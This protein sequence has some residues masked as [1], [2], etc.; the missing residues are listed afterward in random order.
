MRRDS[1]EQGARSQRTAVNFTEYA[2]S[3]KRKTMVPLLAP[4]RKDSTNLYAYRRTIGSHWYL[5]SYHSAANRYCI[6]GSLRKITANFYSLPA[7]CSLLSHSLIP[8]ANAE[9]EL[10]KFH[11]LLINRSTDIA[12]PSRHPAVSYLQRRRQMARPLCWF[13][14]DV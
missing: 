10:H 3:K 14:S 4:R 5:F 2:R 13:S 9:W 1:V 12:L 6:F 7:T 8:L 11:P